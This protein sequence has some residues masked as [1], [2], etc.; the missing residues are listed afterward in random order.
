MTTINDLEQINAEA[1][2]TLSEIGFAR[3]EH[4]LSEQMDTGKLGS[5]LRM[6][7]KSFI[8]DWNHRETD[9]SHRIKV[10]PMYKHMA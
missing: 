1:M 6:T 9:L 3:Y 2:M 7:L 10:A 4:F 5:M 8:S